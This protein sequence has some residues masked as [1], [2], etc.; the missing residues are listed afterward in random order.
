MSV[1][2]MQ[3]GLSAN[4]QCCGTHELCKTR[5]YEFVLLVIEKVL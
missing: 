4:T 5:F 1:F 3:S 2:F